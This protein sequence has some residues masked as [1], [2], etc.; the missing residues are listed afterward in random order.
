M[1][2][3]NNRQIEIVYIILEH[4]KGITGSKISKEIEVTTRTIRNDVSSINSVLKKIGCSIHSDKQRGYFILEDDFYAVR[5]FIKQY[6]YENNKKIANNPTERRYYILGQL[7]LKESILIYTLAEELYVSEQTIYKDIK[8]LMQTLKEKYYFNHISFSNGM[9]ALQAPEM[10][11]RIL[12]YRVI[13]DEIYLKNSFINSNLYQ[14]TQEY[15]SL[16]KLQYIKEKVCLFCQENDIYLNDR[17][18]FVIV[19]MSLITAVRI[20][21]KKLL[22]KKVEVFYENPALHQMVTNLLNDLHVSYSS[23]DQNLLQNYMETLGFETDKDDYQLETD[24]IIA[25]FFKQVKVKYNYDF[26]SVPSLCDNFKCHLQLAIKRLVMNYQLVNPLVDDF[27]LKYPFA[28]EISM[29]I[30]PILYDRYGLYLNEDEVSFLSL[31]V[32]MFLNVKN[33][34]VNV[35]LVN[36]LQKSFINFIKSWLDLEYKEYIQIVATTPLYRLSKELEKHPVDLIISDTV[37]D[38]S[39]QTPYLIMN[40]L[41]GLQEKEYLNNFIF[42]RADFFSG[43]QVFKKVFNRKN[44]LFVNENLDFT[45]LMKRC[46]DHLVVQGNIQEADSFVDYLI[47]REMVYSTHI[48]NSCFMPHPLIA[49]ACMSGICIVIQKGKTMVNNTLF[50]VGF[51]LALEP[52]LDYNMSYIYELIYKIA[53]SEKTIEFLLSLDDEAECLEYL[54]NIA[55]VMCDNNLN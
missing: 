37:L 49:D 12:F 45:D 43:I 28:F 35:L 8:K 55:Q 20:E 51:V 15:Y 48:C 50:K 18:I 36:S 7:V 38:V 2:W 39:I 40:H 13:K 21:S 27:K 52:R 44:V 41:P 30:V 3:M 42:N 19:W 26:K 24:S 9:V 1:Y 53:S 16:Q 34:K 32:L 14:L 47:S 4:P 6:H 25:E 23:M 29:L 46:A 5:N 33:T 11:L 10:E 17:V 22:E 54:E 31:Y